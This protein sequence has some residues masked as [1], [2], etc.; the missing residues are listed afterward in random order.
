MP[1]SNAAH[2]ALGEYRRNLVLRAAQKAVLY[3]SD[4]NRVH[5][6]LQEWKQQGNISVNDWRLLEVMAA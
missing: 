5:R 4:S 6:L 2:E 1:N 3:P